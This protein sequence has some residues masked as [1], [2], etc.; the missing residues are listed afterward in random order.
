MRDVLLVMVF[1]GVSFALGAMTGYEQKEVEILRGCSTKK[2]VKMTR[3]APVACSI[4]RALPQN[5]TA[6]QEDS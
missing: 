2:Q 4:N 6:Q 3:G 1:F 5:A